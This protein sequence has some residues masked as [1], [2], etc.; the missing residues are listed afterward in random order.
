MKRTIKRWTAG[1][2]VAGAFAAA[3]PIAQAAEQ[4]VPLLVYR[5]GSFAPLG[6]PLAD[7]KL[8][9]LKLSPPSRA[10]HVLKLG[11]HVTNITLTQVWRMTTSKHP[12][13]NITRR[14]KS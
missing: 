13:T 14:S 2:T 12:T 6:I 7:G 3:A 9:Y 4:F 1:L 8:D 11:A 5:T 10:H